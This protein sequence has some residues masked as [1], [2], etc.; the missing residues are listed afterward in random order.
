MKRS[1]F[2]TLVAGV[3]MAYPIAVYFGDQYLRPSD[4]LGGLLA[5]L[6][7]RVLVHAWLTHHYPAKRIAAAAA[8]ALAAIAVVLWLPN[9]SMHWL[10]LYPALFD[11]AVFA[12]FF[13]SLFTRRPLVERFARALRHTELPPPALIYT[14]RV[15]WV[16]SGVMAAVLV[17]A[18]YTAWYAPTRI[19]SLFNGAV[20]YAI[21]GLTFGI[22]YLV[23]LR[24]QQHWSKA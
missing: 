4:L 23:R 20:V 1:L 17:V 19:W 22:E 16:W 21:F 12:M 3:L 18:L 13:G 11:A 24:V 7:A 9:F 10:K 8:L 15:T 14:R 2:G 5:L 6:A